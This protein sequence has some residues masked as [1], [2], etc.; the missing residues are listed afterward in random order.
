[1]KFMSSYKRYRLILRPSKQ[2]EINGQL[3]R[4]QGVKVLFDNNVAVVD[5]KKTIDLM[6]KHP[7][8]MIIF[9]AV[10]EPKT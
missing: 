6:L 8:Y 5:D 10:E 1:M 7:M 4:S 2:K 3:V 9:W